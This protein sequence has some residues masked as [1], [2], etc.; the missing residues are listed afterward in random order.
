METGRRR[1]AAGVKSWLVFIGLVLVFIPGCRVHQR[2]F[3]EGYIQTG[4][5]SWY[6]VEFHGRPT[7]SREIYDM[8]DLTAAHNTLPLGTFVMVTNLSNGK[9]I[10]VKIND[11]GP[12]VKGRVIDLS[13]AAA[14]A[15]GM[16]GPGTAKVRIEVLPDISPPASALKFSVQVGSFIIKEN[17]QALRQE[18]GKIYAGVYIATYTTPQQVYYRVRLRAKTREAAQKLALEL[19]AQG[20]TAI[21]FEDE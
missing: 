10:V 9:S 12:F 3:P 8:N 14:K 20:H 15:L 7:S 19:A 4:E 11:R 18:L 13:Y 1:I 2:Y 6:G 5:A 21:I 16:V 17:A